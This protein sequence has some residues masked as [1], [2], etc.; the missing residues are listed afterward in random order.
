MAGL[1]AWRT[2]WLS[3][4]VETRILGGST[5]RAVSVGEVTALLIGLLAAATGVSG[6]ATWEHTASRSLRVGHVLWA[7]SALLLPLV[8][9]AVMPLGPTRAL[10]PGI[11]DTAWYAFAYA[12]VAPYAAGVVTFVALGLV[13]TFR[14]GQIAG[15]LVTFGA[16]WAM[17][18]VQSVRPPFSEL[19]PL[20]GT[21]GH[22]GAVDHPP[23][24]VLVASAVLSAAWA[25]SVWQGRRRAGA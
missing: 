20:P 3:L 25:I 16:F 11:S 14:L 15:P 1:V 13:A 10:S 19:I 4:G 5:F 12:S 17:A 6:L 24:T 23:A 2:D 21:P 18:V 7:L 22:D 9:L 8:P